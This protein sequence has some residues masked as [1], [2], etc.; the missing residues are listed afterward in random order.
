MAID[1]R[2]NV[3]INGQRVACHTDTMDSEPVVIRGF[4]IEWGRDEYQSPDVSPSSV[5]IT[6]L[7]T[8][9]EWARRI[10]E[11]R[12]IGLTVN[13]TWAGIQA[14]S[15]DLIGPVT[16]FRGRVAHALA[17]PH[18]HRLEDGRRAWTIELTCADRTADFGNAYPG[19]VE[20][21]VENM[22]TRANRIRNLG[23]SA[24]S[25][26]QEVYFW[27]GYT[28]A[29]C[30]ALDVK[31]KSGLELMGAMYESMG[32]DSY[33]YDHD[34]N[35][36]RQ[37]IRLSQPM[38]TYL[39]TFDDTRGAVLPIASDIVVDGVT[40][41]GIGL[42]GCDL[43]GDPLVE[44]DPSTDINRLECTWKDYSTG[45]KDWTTVKE[46]IAPG[47]SR[48]VMKWDSW[49]D[50]GQV[51]DPT[52]EN[53]WKRARE[54]GR[55]PRHPRFTYSP[56][57]LFISERVARW[58]LMAWENTRPAF[59]SGNLAYEWLMAGTADYPP[60]VAPIGGVTTFD[61]RTGWEIEL[62]VHWIH[63]QTPPAAPVDW[64]SLKQIKLTTTQ[65][66]VPWWW[67]LVGLPKPPPVTVGEHTP[68]R[69]LKWGDATNFTGYH[70]DKSVT[71]GDTKHVPDSGAQIK[72]VI[73]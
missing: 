31:D 51:I 48:R 44:A 46:S 30:S 73:E 24:G 12:A 36:V 64:E 39:A 4:S 37:A 38:T 20:W 67:E 7:D 72:D 22:L 65:E 25:S 60:I 10:R 54:E 19:P 62:N 32:N 6:I 70:W 15:L 40:Y 35:V 11:S 55:R 41:P 28:D 16:M 53:V 61:A 58:A 56:G 59:I 21:P 45:Y 42:G 69:D 63:N 33:A 1:V 9:G 27:P 5:T 3:I 29:R 50:A 34:A 13:I 8:T 26:V 57:F 68:A 49:F 47:D 66:D 43:V 52:L 23:L 71:W 18:H 17:Q 2:P 14:N